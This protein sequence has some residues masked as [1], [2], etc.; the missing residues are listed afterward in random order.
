MGVSEIAEMTRETS[1]HYRHAL[2]QSLAFNT[3]ISVRHDLR[4]IWNSVTVSY[5]GSSKIREVRWEK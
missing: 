3:S 1:C 4:F 2:M 5:N